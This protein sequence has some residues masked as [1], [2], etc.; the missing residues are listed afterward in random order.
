MSKPLP[1]CSFHPD[2]SAGDS[3]AASLLWARSHAT[4]ST[5]VRKVLS[6]NVG[7]LSEAR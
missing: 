6:M 2:A 4:Y 3:G 1:V 7:G 5:F